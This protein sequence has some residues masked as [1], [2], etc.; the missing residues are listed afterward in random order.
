MTNLN[1]PFSSHFLGVRNQKGKVRTDFA[2]ALIR[3][4]IGMRK[5]IQEKIVG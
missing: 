3:K 5:N 4:E 2:I 1:V